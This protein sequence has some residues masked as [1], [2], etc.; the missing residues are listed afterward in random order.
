GPSISPGAFN[1]TVTTGVRAVL[2][3]ETTGI[4]APRV[5]WKRNGTPLDINQQPGV[6]RLLSSGSLVLSSPSN[7]D[8]GYFEC[9]AVNDVGEERRVIEVLLQVPPTIEDDVTA[10]TAVKM[11]AVALPCQ[12]QGRPAPVVTW[13]KG[14][15]KLS[16]RGGTYRILPTAAVPSHAGRYT[17]S[18]RNP[19]GV[20]HKHV[21][22]A[23]QEP[24]EIRPMAEEVQVVLHH[25][26]VLPFPPVLSVPRVEYVAVLGQPVSLECVA[27]GQ[28]QPEVTWYRDRRPLL[29]GTH[30]RIFANGTLAIGA[31]QRSDAGVYTC[32]A[33]NLAGRASHDMRLG[34]QVPPMIL[35]GQ[36]E[37]SVIQGF[38][39]LL[40]CAAQ[41]SPEPR[42]SWEKEGAVVPN[43]PGKFTVLRSGEL[44]IE[45]AEPGDGGVFTCVATNAAGSVRQDVRLSV[46]MRPAFKELPGDVTLNV[47]ATVDESGRSSLL[48][49]NVTA[50]HAGTYVCV[51]ENSVGAIRVLSFVRIREPP[52]L[53]GEARM[54]QTVVQGDTAMLD[55]PVHGN[56]S[57]ALRWLR[58][59][60]P[61]LLRSLRLRSFHNGSLA[62]YGVE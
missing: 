39:A 23:V 37:L 47:G 20:A 6:Y 18:A 51:A 2:S 44:I 24:P 4:P 16:A 52:V 9:T 48:V 46:N 33:K 50:A 14:G 35:A 41:G 3:C 19:A 13:T 30:L 22:L 59:G 15:A 17:C 32:T 38:Q 21:T 53:K 10:V 58:D 56:P 36:S 7:E 31:S 60:R 55:C 61:L 57:P 25:G 49:H 27:D 54:S 12:V 42:V 1:V 34:I 11:A 62:L 26:T 8:E 29:D 43:L 5:T 40:P 28:P 45:R